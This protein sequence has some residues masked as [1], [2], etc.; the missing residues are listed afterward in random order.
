[1]EKWFCGYKKGTSSESE[2]SNDIKLDRFGVPA[3][4]IRLVQNC[5]I[6]ILGILNFLFFDFI[7]KKMPFFKIHKNSS[8]KVNK[9]IKNTF[10]QDFWGFHLRLSA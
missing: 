1:M 8:F 4:E 5:K 10:F 2:L 7:Y 9:I 6:A 3:G